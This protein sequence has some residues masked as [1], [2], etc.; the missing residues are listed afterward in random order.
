MPMPRCS[1]LSVTYYRA[2]IV[3][4][5]SSQETPKDQDDLKLK[6]TTALPTMSEQKILDQRSAMIHSEAAQGYR[7]DGVPHDSDDEPMIYEIPM[8]YAAFS[9][10]ERDRL[11]AEGADPNSVILQSELHNHIIRR[12]GESIDDYAKRYSDTMNAMIRRGVSI[13]NDLL[14]ADVVPS[15]FGTEDG[16]FFDLGPESGATKREYR[17][18]SQWISEVSV[19]G[20]T[21]EVPE[22]WLKFEKP[23]GDLNY[24]SGDR[25]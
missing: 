11:I 20:Q 9:R 18:F 6:E 23:A 4:L 19:A 24:D 5:V 2:V 22:K 14:I 8:D 21:Y 3:S 1:G 10:Q 7:D 25:P 15:E 16:R 13:L 12:E 17:E